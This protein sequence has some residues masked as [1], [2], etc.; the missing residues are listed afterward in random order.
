M[1]FYLPLL[2]K[3]NEIFISF[4]DII[5]QIYCDLWYQVSEVFFWP[6]IGSYIMRIY[7]I[8]SE[9]YEI[10]PEKEGIHEV[11][12]R[13][14][15]ACRKRTAKAWSYDWRAALLVVPNLGN[16]FSHKINYADTPKEYRNLIIS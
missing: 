3:A 15:T 7:R 16:R 9:E 13:F 14:A 6:V 12:W 10:Y 4:L 5:L 1:S 11:F 2:P 8:I